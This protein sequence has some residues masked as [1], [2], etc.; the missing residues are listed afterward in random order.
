MTL[1]PEPQSS[2]FDITV[3]ICS[4]GRI[5]FL[6]KA[7]D[8]LLAQTLDRSQ[9]EVLVVLNGSG[10]WAQGF[11][12]E[13]RESS[14]N[15]NIREIVLPEPNLSLAT[16]IGIA[17]AKGEYITVVDDDDWVSP[18]YLE[19]LLS[20]SA[21]NTIVTT[22]VADVL[23]DNSTAPDFDNYINR[24]IG[25]VEGAHIELASVPAV[26][27][28]NTAKLV[29]SK[30]ARTARWRNDLRLSLDT[31]Y[32]TELASNNDL[33]CVILS[34]EDQAIYYRL[35]TSDSHSR[36]D[37]LDLYVREVSMKLDAYEALDRI[38]VN[39]KVDPQPAKNSIRAVVGNI[40]KYLKEHPDDHSKV[41][42]EI[43]QRGLT[44]FP[45]QWLNGYRARD[46]A[47]CFLFPPT[48][49]TSA[50][51]AARRISLRGVCVDVVA[52]SAKK[53]REL[54]HSTN[55]IAREYTGNKKTITCDYGF[56]SWNAWSDYA[57]QGYEWIETQESTRGKYRS[58]YSRSMWP[59]SHALGVLKKVRDPEIHW[60][61]EFSDPLSIDVSDQ[62][63]PGPRPDGEIVE[64]IEAHL[65][66]SNVFI[67]P[68]A[69]SFQWLETV[70]YAL[71][72]EI[73]F[74]NENQ[75]EFML[76][77]IEDPALIERVK[78]RAVV[79][80][81]PV[82]DA[83]LYEV[84]K[85]E[86]GLDDTKINIGYFGNFYPTR[87]LTEVVAALQNL[88]K[89]DQ[90]EVRL[91]I[92]TADPAGIR[93][94]FKAANLG[95]MI[96]THSFVPYFDMLKFTRDFDCLLVNDARTVGDRKINPY[97]PSKVSDYLGSHTPI[98]AVVEE[99]SV[100]SGKDGI[101]YRS[102]LGDVQGAEA[103][104]AQILRDSTKN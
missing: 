94:Q 91:H 89:Q 69:T 39:A 19:A 30:V 56:N 12:K 47:A 33:D 4:T 23:P 41:L 70:T 90:Q 100:L 68:D 88:D 50:F 10:V 102:S 78:A 20:K 74:T 34:S 38:R 98:W 83:K 51:I 46:L 53:F 1:T 92:Y 49:D 18:A 67:P 5:E 43:G 103:V 61:A 77:L 45:F 35:V 25:P 54:D 21:P 60:L 57:T 7:L 58:I 27:Q 72:D 93:E 40:G 81:H 64:E 87:G 8:S 79:S 15:F 66:N 31:V 32:W 104:L 42:Q 99:G 62:L 14:P 22:F 28:F 48:L 3:L 82:P 29:A 24:A 95:H 13:V 2:D 75:L 17:Q 16:N 11:L 86:S 6:S 97:L 101:H 85:A 52:A 26:V 84:S 59:H 9:F 73:L 71:A 65:A 36:S 63:R 55:Q 76:D 96:K 44:E 80:H 37:E